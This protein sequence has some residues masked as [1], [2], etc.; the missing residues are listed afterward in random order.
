M[1]QQIR[2]ELPRLGTRK[3]YH[4]LQEPLREI[5]VGRDRL[6][7]ILRANHMLIEPKR[8]YHIT[9][10]SH[11]RFRKHKNTAK[12]L[13]LTRPEQ[14]WVSDI[15]YVGNR[16]NPMYLALVTD[17]YSKK[18]MGYDTSSSLS[19]IGSIRALKMAIKNKKYAHQLLHHSDRGLQ[20]CSDDY[21]SVLQKH[22]LKCSMTEAYDPY[23]NAV[24][25]R[26]NGVLKQEFLG[27]T[28]GLDLDTTKKLVADSVRIYNNK[29]PHYSCY[30]KTPEQMHL[31]ERIKIKTYKSKR[32]S[33]DIITESL[34]VILQPK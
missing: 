11:H 28:K 31:Q 19:A 5:G 27:N 6:F 1:V 16:E 17:A 24:A 25:E 29:R 23:E 22:K 14:L 10:D 34:N 33:N 20:Y 8:S 18:I 9:T 13:L 3:L 30:Y 32:L 2:L 4:L 26:V 15:T 12:D 21:Q 7:A